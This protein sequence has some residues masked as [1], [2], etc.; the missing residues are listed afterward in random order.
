MVPVARFGRHF[1]GI[2]RALSARNYRVYWYG[3][4]FSSNGGWIYAISSQWLIFHLTGSPIWLG[5]IG[6]AYLAPLFFLGP[7]AGAIS[8]RYGHRRTGIVAM[9]FGIAVLLFTAAAI[10]TSILTPKLMLML[11]IIQGTFFAF[12][13]PARHALIPQLIERKNLSAAIGMNWATYC[14][15]GFTGPVIGGAILSIG[16]SAYDKPMGAAMSYTASAL[17]L[18]CLVVALTQVRVINPLRI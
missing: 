16:N 7:L 15:A 11:T 8:D 14:I 3:H 10:T 13:F 9:S 2:G 17:A 5:A 18:S 1:G 4:L 12:D 6:L